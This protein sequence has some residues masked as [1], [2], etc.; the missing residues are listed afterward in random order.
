MSVSDQA[1]PTHAG[2][3]SARARR[4]RKSAGPVP[5]D[6]ARPMKLSREHSRALQLGFET[7]ARQTTTVLTSA[8][9]AVCHVSLAS[10]EQQ[11]YGEYVESLANPT[12]MTLFSM[13]PVAGTGVLEIPLPATMAC[14]D[15]LLGGPGGAQQPERPLTEIESTVVVDVVERLLAELRYAMWSMVPL[16]PNVTKIEYSPQFAQAAAASDVMVVA[17]FDLRQNGVDHV[18]T[19]CLPFSG[20]QPYLSA[21][22]HPSVSHRERVERAHSQALVHERMNEVPVDVSVRFR[23][24]LADPQELADLQVGDV[25]RLQHPAAAPLDVTAADIIFAHATAGTQGKR[26]ACLVVAPPTKEN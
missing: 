12:Y 19:I 24:T 6:F 17:G 10:I 18:M 21:T 22:E 13:Q 23:R 3:S 16:E 7:F 15:H 14:V 26:L 4:R 20:L 8:L 9:H 25:V 1:A 5:Y 11:T 2:G